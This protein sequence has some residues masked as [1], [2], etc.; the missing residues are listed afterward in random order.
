MIN[1]KYL[2]K[3]NSMD[4]LTNISCIH[5]QYLSNIL[6]GMIDNMMSY[7][8]ININL[9]IVCMLSLGDS[10]LVHMINNQKR[11][12]GMMNIMTHMVDKYLYQLDNIQQNIINKMCCFNICDIMDH[13]KHIVLVINNIHNN[14]QYNNYH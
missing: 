4:Q 7:S 5:Y 14:K 3:S 2:Y 13:I 1:M 8:M 10:N 12:I 6:D 11:K 9:Y